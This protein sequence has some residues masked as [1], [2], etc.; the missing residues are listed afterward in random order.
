MSLKQETVVEQLIRELKEAGCTLVPEEPYRINLDDYDEV[1]PGVYQP[2]I[3]NIK[4][5]SNAEKFQEQQKCQEQ[6]KSVK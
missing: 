6:S 5:I 4:N 2:K 3:N 1:E